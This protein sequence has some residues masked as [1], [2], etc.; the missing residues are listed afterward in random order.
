MEKA[1]FAGGCF[2]CVMPPFQ[3]LTGVAAVVAGYTGGHV[4]NPGYELVLTGTTGHR[5]AIEVAYD[6]AKVT[7]EKLLDTFLRTIDPTDSGG[8][9]ADRAESYRTAVYYADERQ[10]E[11]ARRVLQKLGASGRF[12]AP[13]AVEALPLKNFYPAEDYHQT[14]TRDN[15][16][17]FSFY[18]HASGRAGFIADHWSK[19][20]DD[21]LLG[22]SLTE[23]QYRVTQKDATEPPFSGQYYHNKEDG[24]YVDVASGEPLFSSRDKFDSG[25]GWPSFTR[26]IDQ[27][28]ITERRDGSH[29]MERVE[30][31]S[32]TGDSHLGHVFADGPKEAT[33]L[34]Y[35]VNSASLRFIPKEKMAAEGY[36]SYLHFV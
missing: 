29:G 23:E 7:Y 19:K 18:E 2:W 15:P 5:E 6:P 10:E 20:A 24:I 1:V 27:A 12:A 30:V 34:R 26:P 33:G 17:K 31:R 8:Q 14:Y 28:A 4:E 25:S 9:F 11:T 21:R 3:N 32:L 16:E 22:Q 36:A 35:C 13:I